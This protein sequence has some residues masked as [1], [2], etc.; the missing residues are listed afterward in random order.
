MEKLN[1][2]LLIVLLLIF[3]LVMASCAGPPK[4]HS[5]PVAKDAPDIT[6]TMYL[7]GGRIIECEIVWEGIASQ[8]LCKKSGNIIAYSAGD[9]DL[10][11]TFG[12]SSAKE[13][14]ERC[15][16]RVKQRELMSSPKIVTTEQEKWMK[17]QESERGRR[18]IQELSKKY[19]WTDKHGEKHI[20][21]KELIELEKRR[22]EDKLLRTS[23]SSEF[24]EHIRNKIK[25]LER[26]PAMYFYKKSEKPAPIVVHTW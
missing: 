22:L 20:V 1:K 2:M 7:K 16:E 11:R 12:K 21:T 19:F 4:T 18:K 23:G 14:A 13:V 3:N 25:E 9:V 8:I 5:T 6:K 15:E 17:K 26:D 24:K 10:I